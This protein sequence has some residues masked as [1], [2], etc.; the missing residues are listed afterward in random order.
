VPSIRRRHHSEEH[1]TQNATPGV[2]PLYHARVSQAARFIR[3]RGAA[4]HNLK[5]L[6]VDIPRDCMVVIT[7]VSGSGKSSL[8]FDTIF[9][10]GQRKYMESLSAYARQFLTQWQKPDV[11]SIEGLPP[12]IA[13][14]QRTGGHNPRSTVATITEIYDYLRVLFARCATPTCWARTGGTTTRPRTCGRPIA[15]TSATQIVDA[16]MGFDGQRLM[17]CSPVIRGKK[18]FHGAVIEGLRKHGFVRARVDGTIV[19]V[20]DAL[21]EGTEN[22]L[23]IGRYEQ[24]TIEAVVDRIVI[25]PDVRQRLADS[26]EVAMRLSD[27]LLTALVDTDGA[28]VEHRYSEKLACSEHPQS[29]LDEMAPRLFSFNSPYGACRQCDGLGVVSEFDDQLIVPDGSLGI[30][31]GA[32]EPWRKN[33]KRM[34]MYY[35][36][37][38]RRFCDRAEVTRTTPYEKLPKTIRRILMEGT[39]EAD[40]SRLGFTF[41]G[42]I[43]SLRRR[44]E[45]SDSDFV[46][47]KLRGYMSSTE[48]PGCGGR[49]LRPASLHVRLPGADGVNI[50]E[51][52]AM[53]LTFTDISRVP[54]TRRNDFDS[55]TPKSFG[56]SSGVKS[57]M[58]SS[59][60]V[61]RSA[62]SNRPG[63]VSPPSCPVS[64][65][66]PNSSLFRKVASRLPQ[67]TSTNGSLARFD[68]AW[69]MRAM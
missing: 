27:G 25:K 66:A 13:I 62:N 65:S 18:G 5:S 17:I 55:R 22:P 45:K 42:V 68:T 29:S 21:K 3:V 47:E 61:P 39:T 8:A 11:E 15:A 6:D 48:C 59:K 60:T 63:L 57:P 9:A 37:L 51:V 35:G 49:R 16:L 1:R 50:A 36:R 56:C 30:G 32:I 28:W 33:G 12:T 41:E 43:P 58:E 4:E 14:E 53:S 24:H 20:R 52:A 69:I 38:M 10:E 54:P 67:F 23:G 46:K 7:G 19:D 44:Y 2:N 26:V 64:F 34:N 31:D 40:E